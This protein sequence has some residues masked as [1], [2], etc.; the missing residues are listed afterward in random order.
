MRQFYILNF[1]KKA[2]VKKT[3]TNSLKH[4]FWI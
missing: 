4:A 3:V 1:K 2:L